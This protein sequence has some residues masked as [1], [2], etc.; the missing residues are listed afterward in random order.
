MNPLSHFVSGQSM[1]SAGKTVPILNPATGREVGVAPMGL[2]SEVDAAIS[3]AKAAL[4]AWSRLGLQQR[5]NL[6]FDLRQCLNENIDEVI[7]LVVI[8]T[9]KTLTDAT[10][11]VTRAVEIIGHATA[12]TILSATPYTRGDCHR[13][14]HL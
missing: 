9:G 1:P 6:L 3:G 5:I 12:T 10:M 7:K 4:S 13:D 8:E 2:V 11:E 14:Q